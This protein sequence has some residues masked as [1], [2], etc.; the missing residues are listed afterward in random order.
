MH[1]AQSSLHNLQA[2]VCTLVAFTQSWET[3]DRFH[4]RIV[5]DCTNA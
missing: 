2:P 4:P 1:A 5:S 3:H